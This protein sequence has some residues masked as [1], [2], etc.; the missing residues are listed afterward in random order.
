MPHLVL[1]RKVGETIVVSGDIEVEIV[2][3]IGNTVKIGV[4]A[5]E[6][7]SVNRGEIEDRI[8]KTTSEIP[9]ASLP[10]KDRGAA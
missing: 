10:E 4:R 1:S 5:P 6:I 7:V 9:R 8:R 3:I 2:K